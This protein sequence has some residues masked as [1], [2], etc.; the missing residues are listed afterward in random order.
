MYISLNGDI[1]HKEQARISPFDHGFLYGLGLFETFR[2]YDGH[3]FLLDDHLRR[4]ND[5]LISI[6]IDFHLT[7]QDLLDQLNPL[8]KENGFK[9][10]R[11]RLNVSAGNADVGLQAAPYTEPNILL[12]ASE[13]PA[14]PT[15]N[16]KQ[17]TILALAR[18]T[19]EG[20]ERLK[21]HHFLN[22]VLAK[23][24]IGSNPNIE[25]IF[26]T[27]E[28][29]VAEGIT[30][31]LF[32]TKNDILYSPSA[33][34]GILNGITRQFIIDL[35]YS[36]GWIV[37]EGFYHIG[38]VKQADEVFMT[39]SIQEIIPLSSLEERPLPG[40]KGLKVNELTKLYGQYRK[41]LWSRLEL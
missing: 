31:N 20:K 32:W 26:L 33:G 5:G 36:Q 22:N 4:L 14:V 3:P 27:S 19:P 11:I 34:T 35:A 29:Y 18:N 8:L 2:V 37:E 17:G 15:L 10:A 24:E 30:S 12:F 28:G 39:N 1:I 9:N 21:S 7:R 40:L 41:R 38:D 25:G 6:N 16:E 23:H 13:L